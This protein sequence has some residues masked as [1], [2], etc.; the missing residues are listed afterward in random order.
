MPIKKVN[1]HGK[2]EK[3][4]THIKQ[5]LYIA[6]LSMV[7]IILQ[8]HTETDDSHIIKSTAIPDNEQ[9]PNLPTQAQLKYG[10]ADDYN[11][12]RGVF[13]DKNSGRVIID[14]NGCVWFLSENITAGSGKIDLDL[15]PLHHSMDELNKSHKSQKP[16]KPD[17]ICQ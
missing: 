6:A 13:L 14:S 15:F 4:K 9:T 7:P 16:P 17:E 1:N 2:H 10:K 12:H 11:N 3:M 8:A 5:L